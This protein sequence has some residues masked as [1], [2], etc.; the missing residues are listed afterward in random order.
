[1][2]SP[3][4]AGAVA[5]LLQANPKLQSR[6]VRDIL[7]NTAVPK[8]WSLGPQYGILDSTFRQGAGLLDIY[9]AIV[10]T[11]RV[12]PGKLALGESQGGPVTATLTVSNNSA[13]DVTY[14]LSFEAGIAVAG[15]F[16]QS[17]WG[18]NES[19]AFSSNSITVPAGGEVSVNATITAPPIDPTGNAGVPDQSLYGGWIVFTPVGGD[20]ITLRVPYAGFVGDY[21]SIQ[22]LAPTANGFPWLAKIVGLSYV[23]QLDGAVFTMAG[24][25]IAH[26]LLH[27]DQQFQQLQMQVIDPATGRNFQYIDNEKYLPRNSS[28]TGFFDFAWD[29]TTF[30]PSGKKAF[31]VP[32]GS[33]VVNVRALKALGNPDNPADWQTWTSPHFTIA[34]P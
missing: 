19:V 23:K 28:A 25:D 34:R 18:S 32:N 11:T 14:N 16:V 33:F 31:T 3:H 5:L 12:T 2:S 7:L 8:L 20:G 24:G 21:Q 30:T 9:D 6:K 26:I 27:I 15:T 4:V 29:G 1:M 10:A 13:D 17:F 22:P